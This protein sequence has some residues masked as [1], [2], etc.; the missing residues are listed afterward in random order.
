MR[1]AAASNA[2]WGGLGGSAGRHISCTMRPRQ[3][4]Q[5]REGPACPGTASTKIPLRHAQGV[6][7]ARP[8]PAGPARQG[9]SAPWGRACCLALSG[10]HLLHAYNKKK[11]HLEEDGG[12][13]NLL[14]VGLVAV[15]QVAACAGRRGQ[16]SGA[17]GEGV[18]VEPSP[19]EGAPHAAAAAQPKFAPATGPAQRWLESRCRRGAVG[20]VVGAAA[21]AGKR[22]RTL[23]PAGP[24]RA[25]GRAP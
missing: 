13:G 7:G 2:T 16:A 14:G 21:S 24:H 4:T 10:P 15:R 18:G 9:C 25:A 12:G 3:P 23:Y 1:V 22:C 8:R 19:G 6:T 20:R 11:P 5:A 17:R